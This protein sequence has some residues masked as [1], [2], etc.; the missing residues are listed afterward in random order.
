MAQEDV[1]V[2]P[3]LGMAVENPNRDASS[4]G[5]HGFSYQKYCELAMRM[6]K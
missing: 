5:E 4:E 3:M 6:Q 2:C 1:E